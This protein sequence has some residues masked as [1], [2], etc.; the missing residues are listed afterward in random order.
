MGEKIIVGPVTKGLRNDVLPFNVD[1]DS[2]PVLLNAYQW[3]GRIKRKRGTS[4]VNRLQRFFNSTLS[5]Y[6]PGST[7]ITL[8]NDGMGNGTGNLLTGFTTLQTNATLVAGSISIIDTSNGNE[9]YTD[10]ASNGILVGSTGGSGTI[11]YATGA[12]VITGA[13][14]HVVT[15]TFI[16]Y[17]DL[18]VMGLRDFLNPSNQINSAEFPGTLGFDTTY[19]YN[20]VTTLNASTGLYPVYDVSF[21][22]NPA[23]NGV[24]LPGYTPKTNP[25]P[26]TWNGQ[27]YQQ[28]WSTNY[29]GAFWATNG[30]TV[31]FT[32]ANIGMQY[33]P[34]TGITVVAGGP[35]AIAT[36]TI[37]GHGLVVGDFVFIN[38]VV[39]FLNTSAPA[40]TFST[41]NF[42]TGYVTAVVDANN[43]TVE[44]PNATLQNTYTSGGI[45]QYLTNRSSTTVDCLRWYDGD[46]TN[47]SATNPM[48][49]GT[50]GWVN[51]APPISYKAFGIADLIPAQYY[52]VGARMIYQF[53][54]RIIFFAPVVQTSS[55]GSQV[56]L[57]DT[58]IYSQNGTP[59][60]TA[61]F[62]GDPTLVTTVF[63]PILT[64]INQT[65]TA[66]AYFSDITGYGGFITA[67]VDQEILT[68]G[69]NED[70]LIVGFTRLQTRLIYSGND[71][72]PFNF[73]IINSELGSGSTFS[74]ITLDKGIMTKG[75]RGYIITAQTESR[76]FDLDIPDQVFQTMLP[77]NGPERV[78]AQ[79][80][81][82]NE[83]VYFTYP[84]VTQ[85]YVY[86]GQTLQYN[87]R[88]ATWAIFNESYTTYGTFRSSTGLTWAT[89]GT[90]YP[91]WASWNE[92][93]SAGS[94]AAEVP[95]VI[96][97]NTQ[98]FVIMRDVGTNEATSLY[99]EGIATGGI[100]TSPNHCLNTGDY[101]IISDAL[102]TVASLVNGK[103][104]SVSVLTKDT[105]AVDPPFSGIFTYLGG[106]LI[107]R[108]YV[109]FFQTR[110][111]P[112]S[113][114]MAHK[115]RLGFQNYLLT[116][117]SAGQITLLIYLSQD[118][119]DAWNTPP[120][121]PAP[122]SVNNSLIYNTPLFTSPEFYIQ[123]CGNISLGN[124]GDGV[125]LTY[126]FNLFSLFS[127]NTN[128]VPGS[129][130][131]QVGNV[132][133]F[134]DNGTG[135]FT[136]TGT[137]SNLSTINYS[138]GSLVLK[139]LVAPTNQPTLINFQ[140]T[141]TNILSPTAEFQQQI[142]HRVNT[143]LIGD[144]VQL[145]FTM[146]DSQ[147][148]DVTISNQFAEIE[149]H[150]FVIDV[151]PS[152][153]LA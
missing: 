48:L 77:N 68:L 17:P 89:V 142:W 84:A 82:I 113:W 87:Y 126:N 152:Q 127:I 67:G 151:Q 19:S 132:A 128:L 106:G 53:K 97:G 96:G 72:V 83:W 141:V 7:T 140:Y 136:V 13:A 51:F 65:A 103:I 52:L 49:T 12:F 139:F 38:E 120:I 21:Y 123:N 138:T 15:A 2:F 34:I 76:R 44:F 73:F 85:S 27:D 91:T 26:T 112:I 90:R 62:T 145:G 133:T 8:G 93:W 108:M 35:P 115:T 119:N 134:Q 10:P 54:D 149:L 107:T 130:F 9:V 117:T 47:G 74:S 70:V 43:V 71:V 81:Y 86:P 45:A 39:G 66:N 99:I 32:T 59:Y 31:P 37:V 92:P 11:N 57:Q 55:P 80:D 129:V 105:F 125:S 122:N 102:G 60:Y 23:V 124:V 16:Y 18:P 20:I 58:I 6:N 22:K 147:M 153:C 40:G 131:V 61:S 75:S 88:D 36:I 135:G 41:I 25:T 121:I 46:P 94:S 3:R 116:A 146:S 98:G 30:V 64:P 24:T 1:N 111:F 33:K 69:P 109:P 150:G 118:A 95:K 56:Y 148:R 42:Q 79:R 5:S 78:T 144:T 114:A 50:R 14:G 101:I 29:Q 110:Q 4:I 63:N 100:I 137:G 143:S 28:I 104:F